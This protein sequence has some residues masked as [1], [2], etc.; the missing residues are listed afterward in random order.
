MTELHDHEPK[1]FYWD[2]ETEHCPHK[3]IP[4]RHTDAWDEW[5]TLGHQPYDDGILCLSAPAG[6]G[7]P[8]CTAE[9]GDMIP[10]S[11]C[12]NRSHT[13]PQQ[14]A[15]KPEHRP[16]TVEAAGLECL[17]RECDEFFDDNGNEITSLEA[18]SHFQSME[19]CEACSEP[20][21][22]DADPFPPV[23]AWADCAHAKAGA[24]QR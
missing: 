17:E 18:C 23:V 13:R 8:A 20:P 15:A 2:A 22:G 11:R 6:T 14:G 9:S 4:E 24:V 3:P 16:V 10:W 1:Q 5:M 19:V 12:E 21:P 7:C